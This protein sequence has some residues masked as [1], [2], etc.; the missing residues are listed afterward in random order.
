[1]RGD[2]TKASIAFIGTGAMGAPMAAR[3][4]ASGFEVTVNSRSRARAEG[5]IASGANWADTAAEAAARSKIVLTCLTDNQATEAVYLGEKGILSGG[6]PDC[7]VDLAT[8]GP[9]LSRKLAQALGHA[10]VGFVDAP[11]TGGVPKARDGT[12]TI[13]ASGKVSSIELARPALS[14]VGSRIYV[15]GES[16]GQA[17]QAKLINNMLNY[18]ALAATCEAMV[19]GA[20]AGLDVETLVQVVNAGSGKNSA[21]ELKFPMAILPRTFNYGSTHHTTHKDLSLFLEMA[22]ELDVPSP[23]ASHIFQLWRTWQRDH[24]DEDFTTIARMFEG[25]SGVQMSPGDRKPR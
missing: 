2:M 15:V 19:V 13:I 10:G 12:L 23:I 6:R 22:D 8:S 24:A 4:L 14:A 11:V 1:M 17:Q 3:L 7:V 18:T 16:P 9:D 25:W 21:T 20:K 5:L